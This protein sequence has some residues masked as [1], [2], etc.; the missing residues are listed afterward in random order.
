MIGKITE[1][2]VKMEISIQK[3]V[4]ESKENDDKEMTNL[5]MKSWKWRLQIQKE[6]Y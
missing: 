5:K 3:H 6:R 2:I 4:E 1:L